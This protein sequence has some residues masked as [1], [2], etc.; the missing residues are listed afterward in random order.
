MMLSAKMFG[1]S[2]ENRTRVSALARRHNSHYTIP[3]SEGSESMQAYFLDPNEKVNE[4]YL[5]S[6]EILM[7]YRRQNKAALK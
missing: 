4:V 5:L 6:S 2:N 7:K 3:A 1:A